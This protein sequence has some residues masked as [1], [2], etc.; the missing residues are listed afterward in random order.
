MSLSEEE[1][2]VSEAAHNAEF[3]GRLKG[4]A[5]LIFGMI[6]NSVSRDLSSQIAAYS[7]VLIVACYR[8]P[9]WLMAVAET[10]NKEQPG[11]VAN[12]TDG[13]ASL[14]VKYLPISQLDE[15]DATP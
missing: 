12:L 15:S 7:S 2:V 4:T 6:G 8:N 11:S 14:L 13:M 5:S 10:I 9:E 1:R 3:S